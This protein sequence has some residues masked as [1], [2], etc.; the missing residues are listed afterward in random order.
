MTKGNSPRL[1][2]NI[3][4]V[5]V[6]QPMVIPC[7]KNL[8][9]QPHVYAQNPNDDQLGHACTRLRS[10]LSTPAEAPLAWAPAQCDPGPLELLTWVCLV[11][12]VPVLVGFEEKPKG[13]HVG[14]R[15]PKR[16]LRDTLRN[17]S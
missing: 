14:C 16:H 5:V 1:V 4:V 2:G 10:G 15:N 6:F 7:I 8:L 9:I 17:P 11:L 3:I 12:R 13:N